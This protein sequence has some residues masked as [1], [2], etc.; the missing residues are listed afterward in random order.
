MADASYLK[1][2]LQ[3]K[4]G[5]RTPAELDNAIKTMKLL[6]LGAMTSAPKPNNRK[7]CHEW[8]S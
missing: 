4:Y 8:A 5:I 3:E 6:D 1:H 7:E 2:V